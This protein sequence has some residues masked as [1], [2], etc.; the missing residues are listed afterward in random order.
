M[1]AI[2]EMLIFETFHKQDQ[3]QD[4]SSFLQQKTQYLLSLNNNLV[5]RTGFEPMN[6]CVKG[7]CVQPLH[8]RAKK[9]NGGL[10]GT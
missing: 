7:M 8:Q 1:C 4:Q 5:T 9:Q 3:K 10:G 6:A 2:L